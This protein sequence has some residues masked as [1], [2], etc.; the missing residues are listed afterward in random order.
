MSLVPVRFVFPIRSGHVCACWPYDRAHEVFG[1]CR[2]DADD[3]W[4]RP[5]IG[6]PRHRVHKVAGEAKQPPR[7][8]QAS[9]RWFRPRWYATSPLGC[10]SNGAAGGGNPRV[11]AAGS[12]TVGEAPECP[13]SP[14]SAPIPSTHPQQP[15]LSTPGSQ[16]ALSG[17]EA[18]LRKWAGFQ[19]GVCGHALRRSPNPNPNPKKGPNPNPT[20]LAARRRR[21]HDKELAVAGGGRA[22]AV[23]RAPHARWAL[24]APTHP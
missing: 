17:Q 22:A 10:G 23:G 18:A 13:R 24:H 21:R 7:H 8:L 15:L 3:E 1:R 20:L 6:R 12:A 9:R 19:G 5:H 2:G 4:R 16:A 14:P 11:K